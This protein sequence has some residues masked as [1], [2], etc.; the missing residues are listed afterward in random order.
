MS[1]H[2]KPGVLGGKTRTGKSAL[3]GR[4]TAARRAR[5]A[6]FIPQ[7]VEETPGVETPHPSRKPGR[8]SVWRD[9]RERGASWEL[10]SCCGMNSALHQKRPRSAEFRLRR[11]SGGPKTPP[12]VKPLCSETLRMWS[13]C[14]MLRTWKSALRR[15]PQTA[16]SHSVRVAW[17]S[18]RSGEPRR[19]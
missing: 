5:S 18:A 12:P 19:V 17:A 1:S 11:S 14:Q 2:C 9:R 3:L 16:A 13:V 10:S 4:R 8:S 7:R 6:E 15:E